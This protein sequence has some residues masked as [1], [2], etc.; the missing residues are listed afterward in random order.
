[1]VNTFNPSN[2]EVQARGCLGVTDQP[3]LSK[4]KKKSEKQPKG[5]KKRGGRWGRDTKDGTGREGQRTHGL[6][7][8]GKALS[9]PGVDPVLCSSFLLTQ[10]WNFLWKL[11]IFPVSWQPCS[12]E[13]FFDPLPDTRARTEPSTTVRLQ[14]GKLP[15]GP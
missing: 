3:P 6:G 14:H 15:G 4:K 2:W 5:G 7:G 8:V 13:V 11:C 10:R 1:M 12:G 9:Q